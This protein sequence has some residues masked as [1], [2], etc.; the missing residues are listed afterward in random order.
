[1]ARAEVQCRDATC[2]SHDYQQ[3]LHGLTA[4][5]PQASSEIIRRTLRRFVLMMSGKAGNAGTMHAALLS[6]LPHCCRW[7]FGYSSR[8][9][10]P[11]TLLGLSCVVNTH[12]PTR[13]HQA[14][15][16]NGCMHAIQKSADFLPCSPSDSYN[17]TLHAASGK[18]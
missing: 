4:S 5:S 14:A 6:C 18:I 7:R 15:A 13:N 2:V 11:V 1:M 8:P 9:V 12:C 17:I 3:S 10:Q 16:R